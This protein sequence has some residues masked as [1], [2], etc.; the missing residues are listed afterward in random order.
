MISIEIEDIDKRIEF[1]HR[2]WVMWAEQI[3]YEG[4]Y[5]GRFTIYILYELS[6]E[7]KFKFRIYRLFVYLITYAE[8]VVRSALTLKLL[9]TPAGSITAA[10]TTSLPERIGGDKNFDYRYAWVSLRIVMGGLNSETK[11]LIF[12]CSFSLLRS[13]M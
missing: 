7:L 11:R 10:A 9:F 4:P 6:N 1:T 8:I 12:F 5:K 13:G 2:Q 3:C